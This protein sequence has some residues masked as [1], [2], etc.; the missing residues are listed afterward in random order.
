MFKLL[1]ISMMICI[2]L[3][4]F[5]ADVV[6]RNNSVR[7]EGEERWGGGVYASKIPSLLAAHAQHSNR[8]R[9]PRVAHAQQQYPLA[10]TAGGPRGNRA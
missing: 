3:Y 5:Q 4:A 9:R 1:L 6:V 7:V 2:G 8:R 10:V